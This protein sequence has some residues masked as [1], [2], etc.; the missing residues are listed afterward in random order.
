MS[1][2]PPN[3][4]GF[5]AS[6]VGVLLVVSVLISCDKDV[7]D[8]ESI[9]P[10][11]QQIEV[12]FAFQSEKS[13]MQGITYNGMPNEKTMSFSIPSRA[14]TNLYW[15]VGIVDEEGSN[16]IKT[17]RGCLFLIHKVHPL[18]IDMEYTGGCSR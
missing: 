7:D 9:Y 12:G 18:V 8:P 16:W 10:V 11:R 15:P 17:S 5:V 6:I 4:G 14:A 2:S 3:I 13:Y 1:G